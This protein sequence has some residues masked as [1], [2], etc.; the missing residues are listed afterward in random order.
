MN[1]AICWAGRMT[2]RSAAVAASLALCTMLTPSAGAQS[3][4]FLGTQS[5]LVTGLSE[6]SGVAI[7]SAGNIFIA[8]RG[9]DRVL[10]ETP[11][12]AGGYTQ[13]VID[14]NLS[15]P[16]AVAVDSSGS[17][18]I[19]DRDNYRVY[20]GHGEPKRRLSGDH[21]QERTYRTYRGRN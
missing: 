16:I 13:T 15:L 10:K 12:T 5:T 17:V 2:V 4:Q 3:A 14:T 6:P 9:N 20:Q 11:N 8:D 1:V 7:D 21:R 19:A 18:Y